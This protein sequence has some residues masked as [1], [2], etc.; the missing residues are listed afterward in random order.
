MKT[1]FIAVVIVIVA[2][3]IAAWFVNGGEHFKDVA[4]VCYGFVIGWLAAWVAQSVS[5]KK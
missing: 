1:Y 2:V 5:S 4:M 3:L